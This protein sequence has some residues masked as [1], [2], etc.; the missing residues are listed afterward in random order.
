MLVRTIDSFVAARMEVLATHE[1]KG[2]FTNWYHI[3]DRVAKGRPYIILSMPLDPTGVDG[4]CPADRER[5]LLEN[6]RHIV[7]SHNKGDSIILLMTP[8]K[9]TWFKWFKDA[10]FK[11]SLVDK[12]TKRI[13]QLLRP[14][15]FFASLDPKHYKLR[16]ITEGSKEKT[17]DGVITVSRRLYNDV[18]AQSHQRLL[19]AGL[20]EDA[21]L[22]KRL[23]SKNV[24]NARLWFDGDFAKGQV[25]V[26]DLADCD[27]VMHQTNIKS[28]LTSP[29]G[30]FYIGLT[31]QPGKLEARTN[32]QG[33]RVNPSVY[34]A[35]LG[36]K[37]EKT[38]IYKWLLAAIAEKKAMVEEGK[39]EET[40][41]DLILDWMNHRLESS[42]TTLFRMKA[43]EFHHL[44]NIKDSAA[45]M[46]QA[47]LTGLDRMADAWDLSV[48]VKIP[49]ATYCQLISVDAARLLGIDIEVGQGYAIYLPEWMV[50]VVSNADYIKNLRNHGGMDGDDKL[51]QVFFM[52]D[53]EVVVFMQRNPSDRGEYS[54]YRFSGTPPVE[55]PNRELPNLGKQA[56]DFDKEAP[57]PELP[58]KLKKTKK[59]RG[60]YG[61]KHFMRDVKTPSQNPGGI[62]N[63]ITLWNASHPGGERNP[64]LPQMESIVDTMVQTRNLEDIAFINAQAV[65]LRDDLMKSTAMID[66]VLLQKCACFWSE[67]EFPYLMR[68]LAKQKRLGKSWYTKLAEASAATVAVAKE[69]L[70]Q[71]I[72]QTWQRQSFLGLIKDKLSKDTIKMVFDRYNDMCATYGRVPKNMRVGRK[73]SLT[74]EAH[75]WVAKENQIHEDYLVKHFQNKLQLENAWHKV[76]VV[77]AHAAHNHEV[78]TDFIMCTKGK[79]ETYKAIYKKMLSLRTK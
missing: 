17:T 64:Y 61:F 13:S 10:G 37:P 66:E 60:S 63:L 75:E 43:A 36:I 35:G 31:P 55:V 40:L 45:L 18:V 78:R 41:D 57:L 53:G 76:Q 51:L 71:L 23:A 77:L 47:V 33:V 1:D 3:V 56:T 30:E 42:E 44:G 19:D 67:E 38:D 58:S 34:G 28:G 7:L 16:V 26:A 72:L 59:L 48:R 69:E 39:L 20:E 68:K 29:E 73:E 27:V 70:N 6:R 49:G 54:V 21:K 9:T 52:K 74:P 24:H 50:Y 32:R 14:Y 15:P 8:E 25:F 2:R 46:K 5:Y 79:W 11:T 65:K 12:I 4:F 62:I 22:L